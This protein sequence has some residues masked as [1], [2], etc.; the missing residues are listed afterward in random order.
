MLEKQPAAGIQ[1]NRGI[2]NNAPDA[3]QTIGAIRQCHLRLERQAIE[4]QMR[5]AVSH[6]GRIGNNNI[7]TLTGDRRKP[8]AFAEIHLGAEPASVVAGDG[9]CILRQVD[10]H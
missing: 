8:V 3:G 1:M 9:D 5:V 6:I 2:G 4:R 10:G 7:E